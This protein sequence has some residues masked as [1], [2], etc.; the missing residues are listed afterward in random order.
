MH[1]RGC[2]MNKHLE[3][4]ETA[5][6][7]GGQYTGIEGYK[8]SRGSIADMILRPGVSF[9]F[10][11]SNSI[12]WAQR[13]NAAEV[14][15]IVGKKYDTEISPADAAAYITEQITA[16]ESGPQRKSPYITIA[17]SKNG[18]PVLQVK[19]GSAMDAFYLTGLQEAYK[20]VKKGDPKR[21]PVSNKARVKDWVRSQSMIGKYRKLKLQTGENANFERVCIGGKIYTPDDIS[22]MLE[23]LRS[24]KTA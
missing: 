9:K 19:E 17:S 18:S 13:L 11:L 14:A 16:W 3:I 5:S 2:E 21:P 22:P 15:A 12:E 20:Q 1:D 23:E 8:S 24:K 6:K 10:M 7:S 4:I